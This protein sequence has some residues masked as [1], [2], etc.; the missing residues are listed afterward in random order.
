LTALCRAHDTRAAITDCLSVNLPDIATTDRQPEKGRG[1]GRP[2]EG[3]R[4]ALIDAA[5][6][7]FTENDFADVSTEAIL[8]RAGVSRGAMYHHFP[9]KTEL[10]RAAW[11]ASEREA[12][13]RIARAVNPELGPFD[14]L[15]A[16]SSAYLAECARSRELQRLGLRQSRAVLGW[17]GWAEAAAALGIG[18]MVAGVLGA[19]QAGELE[20][21]DVE[22][23]AR[24]VLAA[25]IEAGLLIAT[26]PDPEARFR[27]VE[28]EALR[29]IRGLRGPG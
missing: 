14:A 6:E 29:L 13:E 2:S 20:A 12:M 10:F 3:A 5:R 9:S 11:E 16:G 22:L 7:L 24:L 28:P 18:V 27:Q 4:E 23:T 19:V 17:E 25:L 15:L 1:P 26:A 8:E 21:D